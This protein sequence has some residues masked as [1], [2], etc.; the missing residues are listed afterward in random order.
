MEC[1]ICNKGFPKKD[2]KRCTECRRITCRT[3]RRN[4]ISNGCKSTFSDAIIKF[5]NTEKIICPGGRMSDVITVCGL[6]ESDL[7]GATLIA[8]IMPE[9]IYKIGFLWFDSPPLDITKLKQSYPAELVHFSNPLEAREF[10]TNFI[11]FSE[12][13]AQPNIVIYA[14]DN[15][16]QCMG[17]VAFQY[18]WSSD[19]LVIGYLYVLP[20]HQKK[21]IGK[22]LIRCVMHLYAKIHRR[23][24]HIKYPTSIQ[25]MA[26]PRSIKFWEKMGFVVST[27]LSKMMEYTHMYLAYT[28]MPEY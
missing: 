5:I 7:I 14:T 10:V 26:E 11:V 19:N 23:S 2:C 27:N 12:E 25:V 28:S 8:S 6:F 4:H 1:E 24:G 15:N 3:C 21:G 18:R 9:K 22:K 13:L 17:I 20:S 16:K